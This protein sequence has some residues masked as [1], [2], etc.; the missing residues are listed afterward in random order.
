MQDGD[1]LK[2][3]RLLDEFR[4][5]TWLTAQTL[6]DHRLMYLD[7]EGPISGNR[8]TVSRLTSGTYNTLPD[9][10][11]AEKT[12][13]LLDCPLATQAACRDHTSASPSWR[14]S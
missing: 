2:A 1:V 11:T 7:Y 14:F 12:F 9:A 8:G 6:P 10:A 3:W 5:G 13:A 4:S